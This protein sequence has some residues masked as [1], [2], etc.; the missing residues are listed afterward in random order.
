MFLLI[1]ESLG[2]TELLFILVMALVFFG[3]RK[4]PQLSRSLGKSLAEFRRASEDFKQTW[5]REVSM[6]APFTDTPVSAAPTSEESP[7]LEDGL[8][9]EPLPDTRIGAF[10]AEHTVPRQAKTNDGDEPLN[11]TE[12]AAELKTSEPLQKRDWL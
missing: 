8:H 4:L 11:S 6:E 5:E 12:T 3:P 2:S 1:L 10:S 9:G 7:V